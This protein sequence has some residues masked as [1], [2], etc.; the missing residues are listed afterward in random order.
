VASGDQRLPLGFKGPR[1]RARLQQPLLRSMGKQKSAAAAGA[2]A[3]GPVPRP[4]VLEHTTAEL[5]SLIANLSE[6]EDFASAPL[7]ENGRGCC[8]SCPLLPASGSGSWLALRL[9]AGRA[10]PGKRLAHWRPSPPFSSLS[11]PPPCHALAPLVHRRRPLVG[12]PSCLPGLESRR[13]AH[14]PS[15]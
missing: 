12:S 11:S 7:L 1:R 6:R 15:S 10:K 5:V 3:T 4:P 2:V 14:L 9:R 8:S 13:A